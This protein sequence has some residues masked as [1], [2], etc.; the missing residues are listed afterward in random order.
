LDRRVRLRQTVRDM[1]DDA[2]A[3]AAWEN[4]DGA[5]VTTATIHQDDGEGR[6]TACGT[7]W[8]T[9]CVVEQL[10]VWVAEGEVQ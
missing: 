9:E 7:V 1:V 10:A 4:V 5:Q 2:D 8:P 3:A 6:C